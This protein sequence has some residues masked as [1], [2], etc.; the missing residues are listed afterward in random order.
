MRQKHFCRCDVMVIITIIFNSSIINIIIKDIKHI[1]KR[2]NIVENIV[3]ISISNA[4]ITSNNIYL[5]ISYEQR[6]DRPISHKD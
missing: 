6:G 1:V 2:D 4:S 3:G 5:I